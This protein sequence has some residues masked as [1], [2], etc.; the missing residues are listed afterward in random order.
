MHDLEEMEMP[1]D[2][3]NILVVRLCTLPKDKVIAYLH[4]T[5]SVKNKH[6]GKFTHVDGETLIDIITTYSPYKSSVQAIKE[7]FVIIEKVLH[8]IEG[9]GFREER[10]IYNERLQ[11]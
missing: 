3:N 8:W 10:R 2:S 1:L 4:T 9:L 11:R 7:A 6:D 5:F